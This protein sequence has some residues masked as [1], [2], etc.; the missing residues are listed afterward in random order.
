MFDVCRYKGSYLR[1]RVSRL[2]EHLKL[3]A[4]FFSLFAILIERLY[5]KAEI[6][7]LMFS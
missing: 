6:F 1:E 5:I 2:L 7:I 4:F 3:D